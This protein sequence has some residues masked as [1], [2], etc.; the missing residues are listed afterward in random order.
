M[1]PRWLL[2]VALTACSTTTP[3]PP[4]PPFVAMFDGDGRA[5][6]YGETADGTVFECAHADA[7]PKPSGCDTVE[8]EQLRGMTGLAGYVGD[9]KIAAL[10]AN[11]S[12]IQGA[13]EELCGSANALPCPPWVT[14]L[15]A[16]A[17]SVDGS[18]AALNDGELGCWQ[19]TTPTV[20]GPVAKIKDGYAILTSGE[21]YDTTLMTSIPM[22]AVADVS[23][24]VGGDGN[25]TALSCAITLTGD[26]YCWGRNADGE[27]GDGTTIDRPTPTL[28]ASGFT[29]IETTVLTTCAVSVS[30]GVSCWG[31][32]SGGAITQPT[33]VA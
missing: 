25:P 31:T 13:I 30:N 24:M 9:V 28:V 10:L 6:A 20:P 33:A 27:V 12:V 22:P 17:V 4:S 29:S 15:N 3:S 23:R 8:I 14:L 11:G 16:N 18:C 7:V 26:V 32:F 21:L 5:S 19:G 2:I 1:G